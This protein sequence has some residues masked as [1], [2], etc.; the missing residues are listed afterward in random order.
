MGLATPLTIDTARK[1]EYIWF[2]SR[3]YLNKNMPFIWF[4]AFFSSFIDSKINNANLNRNQCTVSTAS[5]INH[6][7]FFIYNL[8]I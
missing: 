8:M 4:S 1:K 3:I 7:F 5:L 6:Q 2:F